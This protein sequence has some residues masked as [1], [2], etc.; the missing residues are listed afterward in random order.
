MEKMKNIYKI[1]VEKPEGKRPFR[2]HTYR[3]EINIIADLRETGCEGVDLIHLAQDRDQ[4]WGSCE[5][6][7]EHGFHKRKPGNFLR[8]HQI[9]STNSGPSNYLVER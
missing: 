8:D 5:H 6:G 1:L 2:R 9:L 4:W 3:W 7:N